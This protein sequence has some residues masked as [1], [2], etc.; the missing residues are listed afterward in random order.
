M[1]NAYVFLTESNHIEGI[2]RGPTADEQA[3]FERFMSLFQV[4]ATTLGDLQAVFAPKMPLRTKT[5]HNVQVG[6]YIA[7]LGGP[8]ILRRLQA[9]LRRMHS[10]NDPWKI[11]VQFEMLY[12]YCDGN[13][14]TGRMLWAWHMRAIGRDPFA[15]PFLHRFYY[16]TLEAQG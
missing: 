13:G 11:H 2:H 9:L 7:P 1:S 5:H 4:H 6:S 12:P 3:A 8:A 15:L 14:R 10:S 16:Q